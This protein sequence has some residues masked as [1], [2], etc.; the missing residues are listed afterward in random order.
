VFRRSG[1]RD[2]PAD[3]RALA[4]RHAAT[5]GFLAL[6]DEQRAVADTVRA[7]DELGG[8]GGLAR[9]WAEVAA[10]G[11]A[12]TEAYLAAT[13]GQPPCGARAADTRAADERALREIERAREMPLPIGELPGTRRCGLRG[14]QPAPHDPTGAH[15]TP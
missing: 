2:E 9:A 7:A 5:Q 3:E 6:D 14:E 11:D 4:A 12:A 10:V 13:G 15:G 8:S 1:R